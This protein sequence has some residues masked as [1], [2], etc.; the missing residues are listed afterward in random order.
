MQRPKNNLPESNVKSKYRRL[1]G[2]LL[3]AIYIVKTYT[4]CIC[5]YRSDKEQDTPPQ[6]STSQVS[7]DL[8]NTKIF[9]FVNFPSV[10]AI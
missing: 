4:I 9:H 3:V 10:I 5:I 8:S 1:K 7:L 2:Y 6:P